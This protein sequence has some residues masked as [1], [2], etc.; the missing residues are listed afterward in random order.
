MNANEF[1][2]QERA[3]N[4]AKFGRWASTLKIDAADPM[5]LFFEQAP[6]NE[7]EAAQHGNA[8]ANTGNYPVG[9]S[10]CFNVGIS[11]GCGPDC[12]DQVVSVGQRQLFQFMED[13]VIVF[14]DAQDGGDFV[15]NLRLTAA[16]SAGQAFPFGFQS[17]FSQSVTQFLPAGNFDQ[18]AFFWVFGLAFRLLFFARVG[19]AGEFEFIFVQKTSLVQSAGKLLVGKPCFFIGKAC[20]LVRQR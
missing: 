5:K 14:V 17:R 8:L 4:E 9:T 10:E 15:Q 1:K 11:G 3:K 6:R 20:L 2:A 7:L 12:F 19:Q 13:F 18:G 16:G